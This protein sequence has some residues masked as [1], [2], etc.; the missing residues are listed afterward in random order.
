MPPLPGQP[1]GRP[2]SEAVFSGSDAE[3]ETLSGAEPEALVGHVER[4]VGADRHPGREGEPGDDRLGRTTVAHADDRARAG[5]RP[6]GVVLIS[7]AYSLPRRKAS[8]STCSSPDARTLNSDCRGSVDDERRRIGDTLG[9]R[10]RHS[11]A[12]AGPKR[13]EPVAQAETVHRRVAM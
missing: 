10:E 7:S 2:G 5:G 1:S 8:P 11:D 3:D 13:A 12:R 9:L 6:P 4:T